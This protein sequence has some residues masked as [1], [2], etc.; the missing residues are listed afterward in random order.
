VRKIICFR[1]IVLLVSVFVLYGFSW[2]SVFRGRKADIE[3]K[4]EII[5][6]KD[7]KDRLD[8]KENIVIADVRSTNSF[9]ALHIAGAISMP[10][11]YAKLCL[12][13]FPKDQKIVFY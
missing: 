7:L 1:F 2:D 9:N 8:N 4:V 3:G 13:E 12:D 5:S 10:L 6:V 11:K